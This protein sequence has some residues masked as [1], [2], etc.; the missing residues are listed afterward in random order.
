MLRGEAG[1]GKTAVLDVFLDEARSVADVLVG[2]CDPLSTPRPLGPLVD[3]ASAL[4]PTVVSELER[5][6]RGLCLKGVSRRAAAL[7]GD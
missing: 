1:A 5:S 7:G 2:F 6:S 4:G 3:I